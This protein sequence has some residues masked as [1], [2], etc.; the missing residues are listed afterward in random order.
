MTIYVKYYEYNGY[1]T[2]HGGRT[3]TFTAYVDRQRQAI[4]SAHIY[5]A[6][7]ACSRKILPPGAAEEVDE[8]EAALYFERLSAKLFEELDSM[9]GLRREEV[10]VCC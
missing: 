7:T 10:E 1:Q 4:R 3:M 2:K 6:A 8:R 5:E 9:R